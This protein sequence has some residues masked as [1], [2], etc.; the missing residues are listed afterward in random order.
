MKTETVRLGQSVQ[1]EK[2]IENRKRGG[3]YF[4]LPTA[5]KAINTYNALLFGALGQ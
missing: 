2:G 3:I 5:L 4:L 1:I